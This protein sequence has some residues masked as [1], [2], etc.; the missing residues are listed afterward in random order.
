MGLLRAVFD[1]SPLIAFFQELESPETL[2]LLRR[3]GYELLVPQSVFRIEIVR[4]PS[5]R[6]LKRLVREGAIVVLDPLR[7]EEINAFQTRYPA[8]GR[9]ESEAILNGKRFLD[10]GLEVVCV[11]D[12]PPARKVAM[13]LGLPVAGT[14]GL[15]HALQTSGVL[16]RAEARI[17]LA[18]L[19]SS[20]FRIDRN[21]LD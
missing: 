15:I 8:L 1:A 3:I 5:R 9:G 12:E 19:G 2:V 21:L 18:R 4:K 17:L 7:G 20:S 13:R 16:A 14:I 11:L 10:D 6:I